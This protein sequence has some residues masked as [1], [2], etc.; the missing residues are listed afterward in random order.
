VHDFFYIIIYYFLLYSKLRIPRKY[1]FE[2]M[3]GWFK[4]LETK[5]KK[6]KKKRVK[7]E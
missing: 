6:K 5:K 4:K 3:F 2:I 1:F 7:L